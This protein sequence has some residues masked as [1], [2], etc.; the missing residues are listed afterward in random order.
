MNRNHVPLLKYIFSFFNLVWLHPLLP[1]SFSTRLPP[2]V[3]CHS[4]V[5]IHSHNLHGHM[6][7]C[8]HIYAQEHICVHKHTVIYIHICK[9]LAIVCFTKHRIIY[10]PFFSLIPFFFFL[11]FCWIVKM[12]AF[13]PH[14][15]HPLPFFLIFYWFSC[16]CTYFYSS[17]VKK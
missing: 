1:N 4:I 10:T 16:Y 14:N 17:R 8:I 15:T 9:A 11:G 12:L 2:S 7:V 3:T 5:D 13:P 6:I